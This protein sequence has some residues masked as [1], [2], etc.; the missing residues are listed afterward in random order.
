MPDAPLLES[1]LAQWRVIE[2]F[3]R[4][5]SELGPILPA[6]SSWS[7]PERKLKLTHYLSLFLFGLV[8]PVLKTTRAWCSATQ[9]SRVRRELCEGQTVSLG[10]FSEAQHLV[11]PAW[12]E[13]LF[14]ELSRPVPGPAPKD[15]H[16]A[17]QQWFARDGSLLPALPRM[18][19]ALF[20]GGNAKKSGA[21]NN[22]VRLHLSFNLLDD[23]P[24][25]AQVTNG[26]TCERKSWKSQWEPGAAY[27]GDRYYAE[28]Y[29]CLKD[30]AGRGCAY[31]VRLRD[32]AVVTV[33]EELPLSPAD[34]S[35]GVIRQAIVQLGRRPCDRVDGVRVVWVQ[36]ATAGVLRLVT[37]LPPAQAAAELIS[38]MYRRR[39]Q[40]EGFFKWLKCLLGCRHWFAESQR[41][42]TIQIYLALIAAVLLQGATGQRPTKRQM[43]L[44]QLYQMGW[45]TLEEV[46]R[47]IA[48]HHERA[49]SRAAK[50]S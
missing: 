14:T 50:N 47:E 32:E 12:L 49:K 25:V 38:V 13:R 40:V 2:A 8:N 29:Q 34:R 6:Q 23:K 31:I 27:V 46:K 24:A 16:Q 48:A 41:G 33:L 20:G 5:L 9:F 35:A 30:L 7:D 11:E 3:N 39:W 15:P 37:N 21:A 42:A 28:D 44:I 10:S 17:W 18:H 36:S 43:E 4:A 1:D 22:A 26:K 45:V 19:W